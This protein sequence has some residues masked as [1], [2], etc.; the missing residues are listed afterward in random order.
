MINVGSQSLA[1]KVLKVDKKTVQIEFQKPV[2]ANIGDNM[3]MSRRVDN[4][5]RLI[6]WGTIKKNRDK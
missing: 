1:G 4:S 6:G 3:A 5:F 2:C